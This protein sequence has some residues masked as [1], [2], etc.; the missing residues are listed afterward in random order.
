[1]TRLQIHKAAKPQPKGTAEGAE[2]AEICVICGLLCCPQITQKT[3]MN[4]D[5]EQW[6]KRF[7]AFIRLRSRC[8]R[9][10]AA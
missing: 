10:N 4:A 5:N 9:L 1:L 3:Q 6:N 2:G 7:S 8:G